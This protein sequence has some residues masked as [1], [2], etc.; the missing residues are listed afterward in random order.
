MKELFVTY[1]IAIAFKRLGFDDPCFGHY[2]DGSINI[3][4]SSSI[5][6]RTN[7]NNPV[8]KRNLDCVAP[9]WNQALKWLRDKYKIY[10]TISTNYLMVSDDII[11]IDWE[12]YISSDKD[13]DIVSTWSS[14]ETY[15]EALKDG[16]I[17]ALKLI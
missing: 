8:S 15:D 7:S 11:R 1:E 13:D 6:E 12:Y 3:F 17:R 16:L 5:N 4:Y 14:H 10:V 2:L 9:T